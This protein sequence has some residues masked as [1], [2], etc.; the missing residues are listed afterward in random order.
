MLQHFLRVGLLW[1]WPTQVPWRQWVTQLRR[2]LGTTGSGANAAYVEAALTGTSKWTGGA[3]GP[4]GKIYGTPFVA[5]DILIIDPIA[6]TATRSAMGASLPETTNK[7]YG[8]VLGP[9]GKI[10]GIPYVD[11]NLLVINPDSTELSQRLILDNRLNK[12]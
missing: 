2:E 9:D 6:G 7:W 3:L 12:L 5:T 10:Y 1:E 4:D 11:T 8:G